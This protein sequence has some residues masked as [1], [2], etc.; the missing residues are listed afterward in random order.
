MSDK[1]QEKI[2]ERF[3]TVDTSRHM[4]GSSGIGYRL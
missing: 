4:K 2:F 1:D 3:Y